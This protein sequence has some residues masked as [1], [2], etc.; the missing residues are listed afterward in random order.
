M[1][2]ALE[3]VA[4]GDLKSFNSVDSLMDY[5]HSY[6]FMKYEIKVK[7]SCKRSFKRFK[8][9]FDSEFIFKKCVFNDYMGKLKIMNDSIP[10]IMVL[11]HIM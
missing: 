4:K 5:L 9:F 2:L 1:D 10:N 11:A 7:G 3:D 6:S 8:S